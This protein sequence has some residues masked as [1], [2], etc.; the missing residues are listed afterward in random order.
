MPLISLALMDYELQQGIPAYALGERDPVPVEQERIWRSIG[1]V[2]LT[3]LQARLALLFG[4]LPL[5]A[6]PNP[7]S[8]HLGHELCTQLN[9]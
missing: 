3:A 9:W 6:A 2:E 7:H 1:A 8:R 4:A 5:Q